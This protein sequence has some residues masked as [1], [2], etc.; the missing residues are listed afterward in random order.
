MHLANISFIVMGFLEIFFRKR[1]F[2]TRWNVCR[3]CCMCLWSSFVHQ[4]LCFW[5][6]SALSV[7]CQGSHGERIFLQPSTAH[8]SHRQDRGLLFH[9][10]WQHGHGRCGRVD[11]R[12]GRHAAAE[13]Q[14]PDGHHVLGAV[15]LLVL[16]ELA[17]RGSL[18]E[19]ASLR[20]QVV[21][22]HVQEQRFHQLCA[23][24]GQRFRVAVPR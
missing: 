19:D 8:R 20:W 1:C 9:Q 18:W 17:G 15:W 11:L 4:L 14:R 7:F 16:Q 12:D 6:K 5:G 3:V 2:C 24:R 10:R 23:P 22:S 13:L 21:W